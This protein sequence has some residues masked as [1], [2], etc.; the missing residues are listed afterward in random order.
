MPKISVIVPCSKEHWKYLPE[1]LASLEAQTMQ[2]F[3]VVIVSGMTLVD[4]RNAGLD[5]ILIPS[6]D[7][8]LPLDADDTIEPTCLEKLS[9]LLDA[10]PTATAACPN[11]ESALGPGIMENNYLPYCSMFRTSGF[12]YYQQ[13]HPK[14]QGMEDWMYWIDMYQ[15]GEQIVATPEQLFNWKRRPGSMSSKFE[16]NALYGEIKDAMM[17]RYK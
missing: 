10:Y 1:C 17:A 6:P 7:Y 15:R 4:A 13:P 9:E 3:T 11:T 14:I 16:G 5:S 12:Q 2:D 8:W